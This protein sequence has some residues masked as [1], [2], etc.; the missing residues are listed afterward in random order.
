M[1]PGT[2]T[3]RLDKMGFEGVPCGSTGSERAEREA[4]AAQVPVYGVGVEVSQQPGQ[5]PARDP[6]D[7]S[8]RRRL[9]D[10]QPPLRLGAILNGVQQDGLPGPSGSGA[11]RCSPG[12]SRCSPAR[13]GVGREFCP[14]FEW[15]GSRQATMMGTVS[16]RGDP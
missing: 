9:G 7:E 1:P 2:P 14:L 12:G 8:R 4:E 16:R 3:A 5:M 6:L 11:E 15:I 13:R 10:D